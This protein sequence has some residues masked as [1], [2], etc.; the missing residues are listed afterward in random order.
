[1]FVESR[2]ANI[3]TNICIIFWVPIPASYLSLGILAFLNEAPISHLLG[4]CRL[5]KGASAK[6]AGSIVLSGKILILGIKTDSCA[7]F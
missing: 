5:F 4:K 7:H 2:L 1:M 3:Y 6:G